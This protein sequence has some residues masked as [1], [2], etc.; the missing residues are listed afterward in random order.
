MGRRTSRQ[1]DASLEREFRRTINMSAAQIRRFHRGP[2]SKLASLPHIRAELP[3]L[4]SIVETPSKRWTP[5]MW[6]KAR[7]A[8]AFVKRHEAQM[9]AQGK[10][11]GSGR[12]HVTGPRVV[13]LMNW[14]RMTPG[15]V[16][17]RTLMMRE[18]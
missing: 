11:Y 13:A 10:R 6:D 9:R 16:L 18:S 8:V 5:R 17:A 3:L 4:A 2:Y 1:P 7:R 14:G 12:L 15:V